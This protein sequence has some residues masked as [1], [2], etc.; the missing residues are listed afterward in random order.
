MVECP[1]CKVAHHNAELQ[2][3]QLHEQRQDSAAQQA[4]TD[5]AITPARGSTGKRQLPQWW[6]AKFLLA[7]SRAAL[8]NPS[9]VDLS[10]LTGLAT[11]V[12]TK[13]SSTAE[14]M[15]R[16]KTGTSGRAASRGASDVHEDTDFPAGQASIAADSGSTAAPKAAGT[17]DWR[18]RPARS[19]AAAAAV[20]LKTT[21]GAL[22]GTGAGVDAVSFSDESDGEMIG[23]AALLQQRSLDPPVQHSKLHDQE[24]NGISTC[25]TLSN[26]SSDCPAVHQKLEFC[27]SSSTRDGMFVRIVPLF[28][29]DAGAAAHSATVGM[30]PNTPVDLIGKSHW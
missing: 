4:A 21:A 6:N 3:Q 16:G 15:R 27:H 14:A 5:A 9:S 26:S 19:S 30:A 17:T 12:R 23:D 11:V 2:Q 13:L 25:G 1:W 28:D 24:V 20:F 29:D 22:L 7:A 8:T 10:E 18:S